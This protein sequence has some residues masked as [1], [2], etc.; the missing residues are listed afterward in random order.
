MYVMIGDV[1]TT[2]IPL[3]Q[4]QNDYCRARKKTRHQC[5]NVQ[6]HPGSCTY[7]LCLFLL[8]SSTEMKNQ[9]LM[10]NSEL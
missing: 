6:G 7:G 1:N 3:C 10:H 2:L 9:I 8:L 5:P 4:I